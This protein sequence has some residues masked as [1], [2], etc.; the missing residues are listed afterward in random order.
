M[1]ILRQKTVPI[2]LGHNAASDEG[3][4]LHPRLRSQRSGYI[5]EIP[6]LIPL[7]GGEGYVPFCKGR[8]FLQTRLKLKGTP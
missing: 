4:L 3:L 2:S 8:I 1:D 6:Y 5:V 7:V